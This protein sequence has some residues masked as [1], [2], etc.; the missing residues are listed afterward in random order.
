MR[1][2]RSMYLPILSLPLLGLLAVGPAVAGTGHA[3]A[4]HAR[5]AGQVH[6]VRT[7]PDLAPSAMAGFATVDPLGKLDPLTTYDSAGGTVSASNPEIGDYTVTFGGLGFAAGDVQVTQTS[8]GGAC[9]VD[10]W[11]PTGGALQVTVFCY[12]GDGPLSNQP[13]SVLVTQPRTR[14]NGVLDYDWVYKPNGKLTNRWSYNSSHKVNSVRHLATGEYLVTMPGPGLTGASKGTV[15]V[16]PYGPGAG[17]CQVAAWRTTRTGQ[18]ITVR[19]FTSGGRPQNRQFTIMYARSNNLMGQNGKTT[20]NAY[21]NGTGTLYQPKVQ[22]DSKRSARA[23]V[24]HADRGTYEVIFV[25]SDGGRF[26]GGL[27]DMQVTPV[28]G[29]LRY[30]TVATD[31]TRT[32]IAFIACS[33]ASG[34]RADTAFTIQWVVG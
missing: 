34:S 13:F 10:S 24:V 2:A 14:P 20:A 7:T 30:C 12:L 29:A 15:K 25:G 32:P 22:F 18:R 11:A 17:S 16:S 4:L 23:T 28:G 1:P 21:A 31:D 3:R 27:G 9:A 19:C 5:P 26:D 33:N 6:S 8:S